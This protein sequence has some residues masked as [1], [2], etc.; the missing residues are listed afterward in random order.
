MCF[1]FSYIIGFITI[2]LHFGKLF[3]FRK[4]QAFGKTSTL[5][6]HPSHCIISSA[7]FHYA[8]WKALSVGTNIFISFLLQNLLLYLFLVL[9][10][11]FDSFLAKKKD[12]STLGKSLYKFP[13][14]ETRQELLTTQILES[15][16]RN[17]CKSSVWSDVWRGK[18]ATSV[19]TLTVLISEGVHKADKNKKVEYKPTETAEKDET[20]P[21]SNTRNSK[22]AAVGT[23]SLLQKF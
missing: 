6:L 7:E 9:V 10:L 22:S 8:G 18:F 23:M 4:Y 21:P 16:W 19:E 20:L 2:K 3:F 17:L 13:G 14:S 5:T 15:D 11:L 12:Q 1:F